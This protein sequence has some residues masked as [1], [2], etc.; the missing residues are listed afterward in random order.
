ML[1]M[2]DESLIVILINRCVHYDVHVIDADYCECF[3]LFF[4][5]GSILTYSIWL[6]YVCTIQLGYTIGAN[7]KDVFDGGKTVFD[8]NS[9]DDLSCDKIKNDN[10]CFGCTAGMG[11]S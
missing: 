1:G 6:S 10:H 2:M 5:S 3:T 11:S 9:L 7:K 8:I 4:I